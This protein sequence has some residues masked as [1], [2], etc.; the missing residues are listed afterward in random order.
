[1]R[2]S[3]LLKSKPLR[4]TVV[5]FVLLLIIK[6]FLHQSLGYC[7]FFILDCD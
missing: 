7:F 4:S 3:E 5:L 2:M 6:N 1:M